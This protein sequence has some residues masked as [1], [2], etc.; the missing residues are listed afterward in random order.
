MSDGNVIWN[1]LERGKTVETHEISAKGP[2]TRPVEVSS[3]FQLS[4]KGPSSN[5]FTSQPRPE[6][7]VSLK[8]EE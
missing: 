7:K 1:V 2:L 5:N 8:E 4:V 6:T 3:A